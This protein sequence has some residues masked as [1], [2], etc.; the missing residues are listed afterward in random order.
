MY[1]SSL[2]H[3]TLG[4]T[5]LLM[6]SLLGLFQIDRRLSEVRVL[7]IDIVFYKI[8]ESSYRCCC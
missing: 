4:F 8:R 3:G 5:D 7:F 1:G 2:A 6:R